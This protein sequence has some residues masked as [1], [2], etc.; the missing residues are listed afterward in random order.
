[1]SFVP[2]EVYLFK[3]LVL[4]EFQTITLIPPIRENIKGDLTTD[5]KRQVQIEVFGPAL[6]AEHLDECSANLV[7]LVLHVSFTNVVQ[8][9]R[10]TLSCSSNA[11][12]SCLLCK[13]DS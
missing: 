13:V 9:G 12:R 5:G 10:L 3:S 4:N 6:F 2:K 1:M 8:L 7:F 11:S